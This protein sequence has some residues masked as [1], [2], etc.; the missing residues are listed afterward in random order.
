[1]SQQILLEIRD[2]L[3]CPKCFG[4]LEIDISK[5][6]VKCLEDPAHAFPI[7]DGI[8]SFVSKDEIPNKDA[9]WV[10]EYDKNAEMY[11]HLIKLYDEWLGI[12]LE[13]EV[14]KMI[15]EL[16]II[17]PSRIL[18]ISTGTGNVIFRI[19][20]VCPNVNLLFASTDLSLGMLKV[21]KR[22]F[23]TY[24]IKV[25]LFHC[26][27]DRLPFADESFEVIT[28][29]G[30]INTFSDIL[31]ALKEWVRVLKPEGILLISDEGL[32]PAARKTQRGLEIVKANWLFGLSP[33]IEY[34][35]PQVKDIKLWWIARDTFYA[36]ICRKLSKAELALLRTD[37]TED[38][39]I[40]RI[41]EKLLLP[42]LRP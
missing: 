36:I 40:K 13:E 32:S 1:M 11:D 15:K 19:K 9:K 8:P 18:D 21:A 30:G 26:R 42:K 23:S 16:S 25:P 20:E 5:S 39:Q 10:F 7:L 27:V 28:H 2:L 14:R 34:L 29:F 31:A 6:L 12:N 17:E 3:A 4:D 24:D 37:G 22:K 41:V 38:A 33:P 35:P